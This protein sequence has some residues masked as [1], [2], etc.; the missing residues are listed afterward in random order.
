VSA[1][2]ILWALHLAPVPA[3]GGG[4]P[5][6]AS[7]FVS[8]GLANNAGQTARASP[9]TPLAYTRASSSGHR[10]TAVTKWVQPRNFVSLLPTHLRRQ[11]LASLRLAESIDRE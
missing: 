7:K 5:S 3:G 11:L 9:A 6:T 4:Q 2:A 8:V 10:C 1:E